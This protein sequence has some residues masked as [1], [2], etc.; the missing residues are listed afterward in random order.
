MR[1]SFSDF[2]LN[3][4]ARS[5]ARSLVKLAQIIDENMTINFLSLSRHSA[6]NEKFCFL[7]GSFNEYRDKLTHVFLISFQRLLLQNFDEFFGSSTFCGRMNL[8]W[9]F[10]C[11][12]AFFF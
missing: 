7:A 3:K 8:V 1:M 10:S 4:V 2:N 5:K 11:F 9:H 6:L 12:G